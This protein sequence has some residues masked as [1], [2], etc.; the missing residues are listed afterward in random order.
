MGVS[1]LGH[2]QRTGRMMGGRPSVQGLTIDAPGTRDRDDAVWVERRPSG[3]FVLTVSVTAVALHVDRGSP[4]DLIA[5]SRGLNV[6]GEGLRAAMFGE[7]VTTRLA[8][9]DP[10][11]LRP[12]VAHRMTYDSTGGLLGETAFLGDLRSMAA[13]A[14]ASFDDILQT[15]GARL[16]PMCEAALELSRHLWRHRV[17]AVGMP[18]WDS[19]FDAQG[20]LREDILPGDVGKSVVHELMVAAN[21]SAT[22]YLAASGRPVI[23]RNQGPRPGGPGGRYEIV[24]H[25][26][27]SLGVD[28]YAQFTIPLRNYVSL[29]NQRGMCAALQGL[30]APYSVAE[31]AAICAEGN[32]AAQRAES[33]ARTSRTAATERDP[34]GGISLE[35]LDPFAFRRLLRRRGGFDRRTLKDFQRRLEGGLLTHSDAAWLLFGR[36]APSDDSMRSMLLSRMAASPGSIDRVWRIARDDHGIPAF[37]A[38]LI[39]T[40]EEWSAAASVSQLCGTASG[41]DP[42]C[43]R[44]MAMLRLAACALGLPVVDE[45]LPDAPGIRFA[46]TRSRSQLE[47]LTELMGWESPIYVIEEAASGPRGRTARGHVEIMTD[48]FHYRSPQ[49][50]ASH[51]SAA[52]MAA[53]EFAHAALRPYADDVLRRQARLHG[54]DLALLEREEAS[55]GAVRAVESFCTRYGARQKWIWTRERPGIRTFSCSLEISAAGNTLRAY[56]WGGSREDARA[57]AAGGAIGL[58]LGRTPEHDVEPAQ[59]SAAA[60]DAPAEMAVVHAP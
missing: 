14:Y 30:P 17:S 22:R 42:S 21:A 3:D 6:Y 39:R 28:A 12:V 5:A 24:C 52:E 34:M 43:V 7:H 47:S 50:Q 4:D 59:P 54:I 35:R 53:A 60:E 1:I 15:E 46:E 48:S 31:H 37:E 36:D 56:G 23:Y 26:H 25:G 38:E 19:A 44:E 33:V 45:A 58:L 55:D 8:S 20:T 49:V 57:T 10:R 11:V 16:R 2:C 29:V 13:L 27:S 32:L 18:D 51:V 40:D 41:N 9:L